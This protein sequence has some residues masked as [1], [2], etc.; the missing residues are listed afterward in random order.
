MCAFHPKRW[1]AARQ[2]V[3][4]ARKIRRR[5]SR[6]KPR[7]IPA[8]EATS[9]MG[10]RINTNVNAIDTE[11][12][13]MMTS[14]NMSTTMRRLSSGLR[15]NSAADDAAGLAISQK[16]GAQVN[17]LNQA[18][19]NAQDGI[20]LVQTAEGALNETQSILQR[21]RTLAVQ[22]AN[23]TNTQTDRTAIQ[24]EMNQL[25]TEVS[26]ISNTTSFNTKNLLAGG[27]ANQSLAIGANSGE[28]MSFGI[29]AMD[30][31]SLGVAAN[32]ASVSTT[33][34]LANITSVANVGSGFKNG[35]NY[36]VKSTALAAGQ[37][38]DVSGAQ[39]KGVTQGQN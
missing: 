20:S 30:A 24:S 36:T 5:R 12:N 11:R 21:M 31:A 28:T 35:I 14:T 29:S 15:I 26:R 7:F 33:Q 18:V 16:L 27:F 4:A 2:R 6:R 1:H 9:L 19:R 38:T 17:G 34:N 3:A 37:L 22:S 8:E 13:L 10:F 32:G 23:D 39:N 25:A